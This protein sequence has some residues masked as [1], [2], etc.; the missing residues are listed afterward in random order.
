MQIA[1]RDDNPAKIP[2]RSPRERVVQALAYEGIAIAVFAPAYALFF[3]R[4]AAGS[5]ALFVALSA[6]IFLWSPLHN[7]AFDLAELRLCG[8]CASAR[9]QR[10]RIVHALS[11]EISAVILTT[12]IIMS[13]G[14]HGFVDAL[15]LDIVLTVAAVGYAYLFHLAYDRFRPV[16][17]A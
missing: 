3:D 8:R 2:L 12:P 15:S 14:N 11:L 1:K 17:S 10:W 7:F 16:V 4:D 6:A 9:P 5:I 13:M